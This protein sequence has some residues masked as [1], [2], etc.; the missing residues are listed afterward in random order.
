MEFLRFSSSSKTVAGG[1]VRRDSGMHCQEFSYIKFH[2]TVDG[3]R[4]GGASFKAGAFEQF[5]EKLFFILGPDFCLL[6]GVGAGSGSRGSGTLGPTLSRQRLAGA[7]SGGAD[8]RW[9]CL[10]WFA[11]P[12][13]HWGTLR[14]CHRGWALPS[15]LSSSSARETT[16][17]PSAGCVLS[18]S[19]KKLCQEFPPQLQN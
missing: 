10:F 7:E 15:T 3:W 6:W 19:V 2:L 9:A 17:P 16:A 4:K 12:I 8:F 5:S 13:W 14:L 1:S 18:G 11:T